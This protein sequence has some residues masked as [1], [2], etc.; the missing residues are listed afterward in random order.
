MLIR[1][2]GHIRSSEITPYSV[3]LNRRH[4]I[5]RTAKVAAAAALVPG[6]LTACDGPDGMEARPAVRRKPRRESAF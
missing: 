6:L 2:D 4:F 3:Y 1:R 5:G